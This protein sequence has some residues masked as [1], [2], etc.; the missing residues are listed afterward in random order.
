LQQIVDKTIMEA[1]QDGDG[2]LN[3]E[4]FA[5]MVSN[6]VRRAQTPDLLVLT[7][8][9]SLFQDIVKQMTLEDLF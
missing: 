2:K 9:R 8:N 7:T 6:T 5:Q 3:F 4:E 1:D